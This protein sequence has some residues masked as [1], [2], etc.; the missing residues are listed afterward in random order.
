MLFLVEQFS[1]LT[2]LQHFMQTIKPLNTKQ[3]INFKKLSYTLLASIV[4]SLVYN[5][6]SVDG[7]NFIRQPQEIKTLKDIKNISNYDSTNT[8]KKISLPQTIEKTKNDK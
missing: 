4:L 1:P 6:F 8:I 3:R 7:I 2:I 5:Y